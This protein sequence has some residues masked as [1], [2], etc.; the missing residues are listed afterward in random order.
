MPSKNAKKDNVTPG[1]N[2]FNH[3]LFAQRWELLV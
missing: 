3:S 2:T 1:K